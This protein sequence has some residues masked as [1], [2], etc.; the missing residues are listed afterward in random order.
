LDKKNLTGKTIVVTGAN[1]GIGLEA[2]KI[3]ANQGA[4]V[5][6]AVR[7]EQKGEDAV[8]AIKSV[9]KNTIIEV[10][11]LDLADLSSVRSFVAEFNEKF[12]KLDI[13]INNAGI[14]TPPHGQTKDG[15]ELQFGSNH[16]GHFALTGLLLPLLKNTPASRVVTLSS[17]AHR[18]ASIYFDNLDGSKGY[19]PMNFYRQSKL[20]NLLFA[21]ELD[22]RFKQHGISTISLACHP[23]ITAT[24]LFKLGKKDSPQ[25]LQKLLKWLFQSVEM[26]V[27]P[28][29][30][31]A[32]EDSLSGG[33]YIGPDGRGNRTGNPALETPAANV[34]NRETMEKLWDVS[35][36]LTGVVYDFS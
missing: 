24:N 25:L 9:N 7:N 10:M 34:Y 15:F 26:G 29:I 13:L 21:K 3:L 30:Y 27:L 2:A 23:G 1:S 20:A 22:I 33:E 28:T 11:K 18:G 6:M 32:I 31:A 36:T 17:I 4:H 8:A 12:T 16:L 35:E 19:K 5:I 14:M